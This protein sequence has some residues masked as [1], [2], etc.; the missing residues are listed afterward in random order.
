MREE[1]QKQKPEFVVNMAMADVG[2]TSVSQQ[3]HTN[4]LLNIVHAQIQEMELV[5]TKIYQLETTHV[6]MKN[7]YV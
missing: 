1:H 6:A 4:N 7:K 5:R 3:S 2:R